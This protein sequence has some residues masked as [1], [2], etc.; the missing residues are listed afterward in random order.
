MTL[1]DR[2]VVLGVSGSSEAFEVNE[3]AGKLI[4]NGALS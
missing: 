1:T 4:R 3:L 2:R